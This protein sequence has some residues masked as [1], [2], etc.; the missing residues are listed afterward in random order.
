MKKKNKG[1]TLV[2][3]IVVLAILAILAAMLVPALTGYIDKANE[4]KVIATARQYYVAAQTVVSEAYAKNDVI[5]DI[6]LYPAYSTES[7]VIN[8]TLDDD[9]NLYID[10]FKNLAEMSDECTF[11]SITIAEGKIV[12]CDFVID[13]TEVIYNHEEWMIV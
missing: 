12:I 13:G 3:L 2:E 7:I 11:A 5:T 9:G 8:G 4:K 1:F 6:M 10:E